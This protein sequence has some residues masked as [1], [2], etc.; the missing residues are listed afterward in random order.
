[1]AIVIV[2]V[3]GAALSSAGASPPTPDHVVIVIEENHSFQQV[4]G[5][6]EAP[7]MNQLAAQGALLTNMY[8]I[9]HPS[10]PNYLEFYSG[11]NQGFTTNDE[12]LSIPF[13]TPNLGAALI[14]AG[15]SFVG[16]SEDL[17]APGSLA[18]TSGA[19]ARRHV[20][21]ANWQAVGPG[22]PANQVNASVN[23]PMTAFPSDFALLPRVAIVVPNLN[24]DMH[25][26]TIAQADAWLQNN[27]QAYEQWAMTHNSLLIVTWDEDE[28]ASRNRIP[29]IF[30]GPMVRP[31]VYDSAWTLH[32]LH[33]T[34]VD[35]F[36][37]APSG[38]AVNVEPIT[39][40]WAGERMRRSVKFRH[41]VNG[42][43]VDTY[44][45]Q[46]SPAS[47]HAADAKLVID[48]SPLSHG[49]I[50]FDGVFGAGGGQAPGSASVVSAQVMLLTG[51]A[52]SD[53]TASTMALHRM[54]TPWTQ[55]ATWDGL[56]NGVAANNIECAASADFVTL[57]FT[58]DSWKV[59]DVTETVRAWATS[60]D[61]NS[62]NMGWAVLPGGTD[63]WRL[64]SSNAASASDRPVLEVTV[65]CRAD[66]NADGALEVADIF[67]FLNGWF[68]GAA[69]ADFDGIGGLQ[70]A[71]IFAFLN[72]W[73][74]GC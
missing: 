57:P 2:A 23:Q 10:Q 39:G 30:R 3:G 4:I 69:E 59:F 54:L 36:G 49:L 20:P 13:T 60:A 62:A 46:A 32:N 42:A 28:S 72:A 50:R 73:F 11:A 18:W 44:I 74:G 16:Y 64:N 7:Y 19:Y 63:G 22:V 38:A 26:G 55:G 43:C 51:N 65:E 61:P 37:A 34:I 12:P 52:T 40:M 33:R 70:V 58:V 15:A 45:E 29:T 1:L 66:H 53:N 48:G 9:T 5:S 6:A 8:A 27:I 31:G 17:P 71:D 47:I 56:A 14:A 68:A 21:W 24:N 25:D 41:G 35:M 67:A